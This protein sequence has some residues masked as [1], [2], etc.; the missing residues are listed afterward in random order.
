MGVFNSDTGTL[1]KL[2][3]R[4]DGSV[5]EVA[6]FITLLTNAK[7]EAEKLVSE[8]EESR[9]RLDSVE[10]DAKSVINFVESMP[11]FDGGEK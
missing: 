2:E 8:V 10:Q 9:E 1:E 5:S 11:N 3:Q 6:K 7:Q 4:R